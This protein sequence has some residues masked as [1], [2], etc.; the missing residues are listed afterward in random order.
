MLQRANDAGRRRS[1]LE[2]IKSPIERA[3]LED[4]ELGSTVD[5]ESDVE[6]EE[7]YNRADCHR[8]SAS[9][10]P[11]YERVSP[12]EDGTAPPPRFDDKGN[13]LA[14]KHPVCGT[15]CDGAPRRNMVRRPSS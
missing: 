11:D 2:S 3:L 6:W 15:I 12:G 7:V 5:S 8:V 10:N 14:G 1:T 13:L 9:D 4:P